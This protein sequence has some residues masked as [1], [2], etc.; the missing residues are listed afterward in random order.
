MGP[1]VRPLNLT[2]SHGRLICLRVM[3]LPIIKASV[4]SQTHQPLRYETIARTLEI[5]SGKTM[6]LPGVQL[7]SLE[8]THLGQ[9]LN[10]GVD[11]GLLGR[12]HNLIL[13]HDTAVVSVGDVLGDAAVKQDGLLG[14]NAQVGTEPLDIELL[15]FF[16]I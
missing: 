16:A 3:K 15:Y 4:F 6:S 10:E 5:A 12:P 11:V 13:R 7:R 1:E 2:F 9:C 14:H 8:L